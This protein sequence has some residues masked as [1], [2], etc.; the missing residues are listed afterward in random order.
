LALITICS[1]VTM[2]RDLEKKLMFYS[3]LILS[4][5]SISYGTYGQTQ[6]FF[7]EQVGN[8]R[9]QLY[10][11][12]TVHLVYTILTISLCFA[13]ANPA[14]RIFVPSALM[15]ISWGWLLLDINICEAYYV[16]K[17]FCM[18]INFTFVIQ[19]CVIDKPFW[20]GPG[21]FHLWNYVIFPTARRSLL[22]AASIRIITTNPQWETA[23]IL[24]FLGFMDIFASTRMFHLVGLAEFD[25]FCIFGWRD[26]RN[27]NT[28]TSTKSS[29]SYI[30]NSLNQNVELAIKNGY[31]YNYD[32]LESIIRK[33]SGA[34]KVPEQMLQLQSYCNL[35]IKQLDKLTHNEQIWIRSVLESYIPSD[36]GNGSAERNILYFLRWG[37]IPSN[38][39]DDVRHSHPMRAMPLGNAFQ[40][41]LWTTIP[42]FFGAKPKHTAYDLSENC[43]RCDWFISHAWKDKGELKLKML[44]KYLFIHDLVG[45]W[46]IIFLFLAAFSLPI[47]YAIHSEFQRFPGWTLSIVI[48]TIMFLFLL[49]VFLSVNDIIASTFAPW[50][51]S[52]QTVWL[53]K[54]CIDQS[55]PE[56]IKA[57]TNSFHQFLSKCDGMVAFVSNTYFSRIW[58]V[59]ELASFCKILEKQNGRRL[60]LFSLDWPSS[61]FQFESSEV[62]EEEASYFKHFRCRKAECFIPADR[63]WVLGEIRREWGSEQA[64][65]NYVI[66]KLPLIF[67][68]SKQMYGE[69]LKTVASRSLELLFGA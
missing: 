21:D 6:G 32:V 50:S 67:A 5:L 46:V 9:I 59:Y 55:T 48:I 63:G 51:F 61:I 20:T 37:S 56:T 10:A 8:R 30:T 18:I 17:V 45:I 28:G 57:G 7:K 58:C 3:S 1:L 16:E 25:A 68:E 31:I 36:N 26:K 64:F 29:P 12:I 39:P 11:C 40:I 23:Y 24:V 65:D 27:E 14:L 44:R 66:T 53:D 47:G 41:S 38:K 69:Q 62:S 42:C 33:I 54:C 19:T 15:L 43:Q 49:W 22:G 2:N 34:Q 35:L 13:S 4:L 52:R 60:L